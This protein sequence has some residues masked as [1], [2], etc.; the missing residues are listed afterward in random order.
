M[1]L[2]LH[3]GGQTFTLPLVTNGAFDG[4]GFS[5]AYGPGSCTRIGV[6]DQ[7]QVGLTPGSTISGPV[8]IDASFTVPEPAT[9]TLLIV[10]FG[11]SGAALRRP[12]KAVTA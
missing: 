1:T 9:W 11:L 7:A 5:F 2:F 4:P 8:T 12:R 3:S 6:C 10:G